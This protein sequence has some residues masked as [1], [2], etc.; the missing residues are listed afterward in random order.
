M[1]SRIEFRALTITLLITSVVSLC[2]LHR[3]RPVVRMDHVSTL[4]AVVARFYLA[5]NL[6]RFLDR[7]ALAGW[8]QL[9]MVLWSTFIPNVWASSEA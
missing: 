8:I 9:V 2:T 5:P 4:G 6:W 3:R 1:K 7:I